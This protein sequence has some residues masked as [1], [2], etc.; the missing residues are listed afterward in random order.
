MDSLV[1]E[2]F[3]KDVEPFAALSSG[4]L[5]DAFFDFLKRQAQSRYW[6]A[7]TDLLLNETS[8][9]LNEA[10]S[11]PMFGGAKQVRQQAQA[12]Q[13]EAHAAHE[14]SQRENEAFRKATANI[15]DLYEVAMNLSDA[16]SA[17]ERDGLRSWCRSNFGDGRHVVSLNRISDEHVLPHV[18]LICL[19]GY[20]WSEGDEIIKAVA[21]V[22]PQRVVEGISLD[23]AIAVKDFFEA[24]EATVT[25][26]E[27]V[28]P[29]KRVSI[30]EAVR[31]EVW[32]RDEGKCVDCGSRERLEFDHIIPVS[33]GGSNTARNLE[34]RCESCNRRKGATI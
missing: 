13:R 24:S 29:T 15:L 4:A 12:K 21:H 8:M 33:A 11:R 32:R 27:G 5:R 6:I 17:T 34:L 10:R 9:L 7:E 3:D 1:S 26:S 30:S 2:S 25:I 28:S 31:H 22:G 20:S 14:S 19:F 18:A 23:D 16:A